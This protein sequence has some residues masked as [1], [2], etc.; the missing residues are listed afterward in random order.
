M[1]STPIKQLSPTQHTITQEALTDWSKSPYTLKPFDPLSIDFL[2]ALSRELLKHQ[3]YATVPAL[4]ALGFWLRKSNIERIRKENLHWLES[5]SCQTLP[6]GVVFHVCPA[7]VDTMFIYSWALSLLAG[8][9]NVLR[10]S[11]RMQHPHT[12]FLVD[13]I[14]SLI[15]TEHFLLLQNYLVIVQYG[16]E[17]QWNRFFSQLAN[18][19]I[20]WG[21]DETIT[22][23]RTLPTAPHCKDIP[24]SDRISL[25]AIKS[26]SFTALS[27]EKQQEIVRRF[28][29]DSYTFD[30]Q[31]CSSPQ[32]IFWV[33]EQSENCRKH[34]YHLLARI[35]EDTYENEPASIASLKFSR[36]ATD[37]L[38]GRAETIY[39]P[40]NS[41]YFAHAAGKYGTAGCGAGYFYEKNIK[42][43][44]ELSAFV[45][46]KH[47]T[48]S[49]FGFSE[50][51]LKTLTDSLYGKGIDRIVPIGKALEFDYLW[52]GYNLLEELTQKQKIVF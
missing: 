20:L 14:N 25:C 43:L 17:E 36:A 10:I 28:F 13:T 37:I 40:H 3:R 31:G 11:S 48:L 33:G 46:K 41:L 5:N 1:N 18:V 50:T 19:R 6:R 30:Q 29:N 23:F 22:Q 45:T 4:A 2:H 24:F 12:D 32:W 9:K 27:D 38:D 52:D 16:H 49:Y 51:E 15:A 47:Q 35:A 8:N 44:K 7:N 21:G 39:H 26:S 42:T 34:F